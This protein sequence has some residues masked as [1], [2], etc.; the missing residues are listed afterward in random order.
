MFNDKFFDDLFNEKC[1]LL[2]EPLLQLESFSH[3]PKSHPSASSDCPSFALSGGGSGSLG[4]PD[5][6]F[7][8]SQDDSEAKTKLDSAGMDDTFSD[9][10]K[11]KR[12]GKFEH[13]SADLKKQ[14]R[15]EKNKKYAKE[16]RDRKRKYVESLEIDIES[17]KAELETC[18]A[19]LKE[20]ELVEKHKNSL[21]FEL[22]EAMAKV[23][24][25]LNANNQPIANNE[26]F[27]KSLRKAIGQA[28]DE[29]LKVLEMLT[30]SIMQVMLPLPTRISMWMAE[31]NI[32]TTN[33]EKVTQAFSKI[34][35]PEQAKTMAGYMQAIDPT[36]RLRKE[37]NLFT[38]SCSKKIKSALKE[39][40]HA[41][42]KLKLT[43]IKVK[44]HVNDAEMPLYTPFIV[45]MMARVSTEIAANP[46]IKN[47]EICQLFED[48]TIVKEEEGMKE[49][50]V[51]S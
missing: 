12:K 4:E 48:M 36:G 32:D 20:Y 44:N 18:K 41:Y 34:L 21:G 29:Q 39:L 16:S 2:G 51:D 7:N 17:L 19:K 22:Y 38:T 9:K 14:I 23:Y 27:T 13:A 24:Q 26:F 11:S 28:L 3:S 15:A 46:E 40:V 42:K 33:M 35:N 43:N 25:D 49:I 47:C 31:H 1:D 8:E 5:L 45:E 37:H 50:K 10:P 6:L 30:K